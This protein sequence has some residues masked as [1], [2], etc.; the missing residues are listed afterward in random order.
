MYS[1]KLSFFIFSVLVPKIGI[2]GMRLQ[3]PIKMVTIPRP[4]SVP[5]IGINGMRRFGVKGS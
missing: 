3:Q 5:T 1:T 2:N 4:V